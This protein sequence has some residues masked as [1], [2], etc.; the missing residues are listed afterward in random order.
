MPLQAITASEPIP[1]YRIRDRIGAGGY[2]EVWRADA[3]GGLSKAIKFVY[4]FLTED[5]AARE[6][7]ALNRIKSVRHPFLLSLERIEVVDGQLLIVTELADASLKER[8][9]QCRREGLP[10]IPWDELIRCMRDTA[11]VLDF[12]SEEHSLQHLDIK[13]ENLLLLAGRVKVADFGLVKDIHDATASMMGG[14]TPLYAPPEVFDGRP[15]RWSDQYSLAIVYQEMLCGELPFPGT[16]A[17]QLARQHLHA[18][19]RLSGLPEHD[20]EIIARALSKSP[21][22]RFRNCQELVDSLQNAVASRS[23]R[24]SQ[25]AAP[26]PAPNSGGENPRRRRQTEVLEDRPGPDA[27]VEDAGKNVPRVPPPSAAREL[28]PLDLAPQPP[29]LEP[30]LFLGVGRSAGRVLLRLRH[31]LKDRF[32]SLAAV[33]SFQ[34]LLLDTDG[35]E[36]L[37]V[38][39]R[40]GGLEPQEMVALPLR[41]P[42]DYR[43]NSRSL[44]QWLSRRWLYNIPRSLKTE[45]LRPLGRL[46][47]VDHADEVTRR[48]QSAIETAVSDESVSRTEQIAGC[49]VRTD[50]MRIVVIASIS[51]GTGSGMVA[52]LGYLARHL[53][54]RLGLPD[55][56]VY[57]VLTHAT[58]RNPSAAELATVNAYATL[59]ELNHFGRLGGSY[60]GEPAL[61]LPSRRDD[62]PFRDTYLIHLG[63]GLNDDQFEEVVDQVAEYLYLDTAT[64]AAQ[65][66]RACRD[67]EPRQPTTRNLE[68]PLRSFGLHQYSC[69][70]D[71]VLSVALE[72][73]GRYAVVRWIVGTSVECDLPAFRRASVT[74][75][76]H[77]DRT[78]DPA[79][80]QLRVPAEQ[81]AATLHIDFDALIQLASELLEEELGQP[82][83][84]FVTA[85]LQQ[86]AGS[87]PPGTPDALAACVQRVKEYLDQLLGKAPDGRE[88][89]P[90][91]S[92]TLE[93]NLAPQRRELMAERN[94]SI[95]A[96]IWERVEDEEDRLRGAQWVAQ[97]WISRCR[98]IDQQLNELQL[99]IDQQLTDVQ[100]RLETLPQKIRARERDTA[101]G[102]IPL[103]QR[104]CRLR[105]YACVAGN[106]TMMI[107]AVKGHVSSVQE[108]LLD[109]DRELRHLAGQFDTSCTLDA[110]RHTTDS[111]AHAWRQSVVQTLEDNLPRLI[112]HYEDL[113]RRDVLQRAG[114]LRAL[115][116]QG[117]NQRNELPT[118]MRNVARGTVVAVMKHLNVSDV[119]FQENDPQQ[120]ET[121]T[122]AACLDTA[123]PRLVEYGGAKRLLVM[124]PRGSTQV[125]PLEILHEE[126]NE[127]PSVLEN[128]DGD[129]ILCY[130]A[131]QI[132]L[133]QTAVTIID[134][135]ADYAEA[136][137]RLHTRT[138]IAW[139]ALPDLV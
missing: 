97:W 68:I 76:Q 115:L 64:T 126:L 50:T 60:P 51:G 12:M 128:C 42:Q 5:R 57:G 94:A 130:E 138:D 96:W 52:D 88:S 35:K 84:A 132:S 129:F 26:A 89:N 63:D 120:D 106:A 71:D 87:P 137:S 21:T 58:G 70:R 45:G 59:I 3:P 86:L 133:T 7:K 119:L 31:R 8:F 134:G 39:Q 54:A 10:G 13:P 116:I 100:K 33:P 43:D 101:G 73:L 83:D 75:S 72:H 82:A 124:L 62:P 27:W 125:R 41:R 2:G 102:V 135:R 32:Q 38:S 48:L 112:R 56:N 104:L 103:L 74:V 34:M 53:L 46:A 11:E 118:L 110:P 23:G 79:H 95:R 30:T 127:T 117:G 16:T 113:L 65:F 92:G 19:P 36:L 105:L 18:K 44:L 9:D 28:P 77:A 81:L 99:N 67:A 90:P 131:E 15:S 93:N 80:A 139:T 114:G 55:D 24:S 78:Q 85:Q 98:T 111:S 61:H 4:G 14:L 109:L 22:D 25:Y 37:E 108:E 40:Q 29:Q 121:K 47:L 107:Q 136:A 122:L 66:L 6:L 49:P 1:G 17:I 69:L 123:R 20:Q 91:P